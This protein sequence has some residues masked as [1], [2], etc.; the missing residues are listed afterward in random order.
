M[1][2]GRREFLAFATLLAASNT[3]T[4]LIPVNSEQADAVEA[5]QKPNCTLSD[6]LTDMARNNQ[7]YKEVLIRAATECETA[8]KKLDAVLMNKKLGVQ[9]IKNPEAVAK[10]LSSI[11]GEGAYSSVGNVGELAT[12]MRGLITENKDTFK[13]L[14]NSPEDVT[15]E[16]YVGLLKNLAAITFIN[17][18]F[19]GFPRA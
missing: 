17:S 5:T 10:G 9:K 1:T 15:D 14:A 7:K 4:A 13:R 12:T 11:L 8:E 2:F 19:V 3:A 18:T 6:A 16:Q